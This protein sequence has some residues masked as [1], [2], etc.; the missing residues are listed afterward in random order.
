MLPAKGVFFWIMFA[1]EQV[2]ECESEKCASE[3]VS[4]IYQLA[5]L[6]PANLQTYQ[7]ANLQT[8]QLAN[9]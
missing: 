2:C 4:L 3:K 9:L 1:R 8:C 6:Q 5:N 7:L